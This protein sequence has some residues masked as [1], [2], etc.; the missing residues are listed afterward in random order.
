MRI[1]VD[2][3]GGDFFPKAPVDGAIRALNQL[4]P[5]GKLVLVG[6]KDL[7]QSELSNRGVD[8]SAF[9]I[10]HT[11]EVVEMSAAPAR[12]IASKP[13]SSIRIGLEMVKSKELDA[14]VS[15]GNTGAMLVGSTLIIG[16]VEGVI[17]PTIGILFPTT[18]MRP[19]LL[20]DVGANV[21]CKAETL[22]QFGKLGHIFMEEVMKVPNPRVTL[23]NVGEEEGKGSQVLQDAYALLKAQEGLNFIG[24]IE[25]RQVYDG[26]SDVIV[27]D[28]YTGNVLLKFG[29]SLYDVLRSQYPDDEFMERFNFENIGGVPVLGV[30]G[31]SMIGH[32]ISTGK[33]IESMILRAVDSVQSNLT[34]K[35]E[36]AF[37][38]IQS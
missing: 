35:I 1:G 8:H 32:G 4:P 38:S 9:D 20:C 10:V 15:A 31:I 13:D 34:E 3:M 17:R 6:D 2:I 25:G 36:L 5:D 11:T 21:S 37:Q 30:K 33:A 29:E 14:F 7:I 26:P 16:K 12:A 22:N 28:G 19:S 23:L 27:T 24:N 18:N